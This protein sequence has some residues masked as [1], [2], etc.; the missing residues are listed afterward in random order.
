M[1]ISKIKALFQ[2]ELFHGD[3]KKS[4]YFEGWYYKVQDISGD[5]FAFIPGVSI[6]HDSA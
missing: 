5:I 4:P 3:L 2:P 6:G 1:I